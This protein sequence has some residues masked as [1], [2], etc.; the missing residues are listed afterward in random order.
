MKNLI[1]ETIEKIKK[2]NVRPEPRWKYLAKKY[3]VWMSFF[4][5]ALIAAAVFS[6]VIFSH[7]AAG[8][9]FARRHASLFIFLL[10]F[11]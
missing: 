4:A 7:F 1:A 6:V 9:G 5:V 8:L 2:E 10:S 3:S 11:S